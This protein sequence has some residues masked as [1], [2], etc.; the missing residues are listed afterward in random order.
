MTET[1]E[2]KGSWGERRK[3]GEKVGQGAEGETG[4]GRHRRSLWLVAPTHASPATPALA[5]G[6][7]RILLYQQGV[8]LFIFQTLKFILEMNG[9]LHMAEGPQF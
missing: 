8:R 6:H 1:V 3:H 7:I 9:D 4:R 5:I 2:S